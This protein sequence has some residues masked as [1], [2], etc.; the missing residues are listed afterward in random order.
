[1]VYDADSDRNAH[2]QGRNEST[3]TSPPKEAA[4]T[5]SSPGGTIDLHDKAGQRAP[6]EAGLFD[7]FRKFA[8]AEGQASKVMKNDGSLLRDDEKMGIS[9]I[10]NNDRPDIDRLNLRNVLLDSVPGLVKWNQKL[11]RVEADQET[12][13]KHNLYYASG[14]VEIGFD[15]VAVADGAWSK[16]RPLVTDVKA[17]YLGIT[18]IEL[19]LC[20]PNTLEKVATLCLTKVEPSST[21]ETTIVSYELMRLFANRK[22]GLK[23]AEPTGQT[24]MPSERP[25]FGITSATM[26]KM[27]ND[28]L[29]RVVM[30]SFPRRCEC[31]RLKRSG[32]LVLALLLFAMLPISRLLLL[33]LVSML[34][35][36]MLLVGL[37]PRIL[38]IMKAFTYFE[39]GGNSKSTRWS[40]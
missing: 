14:S 15:L 29:S 1:M 28:S 34:P 31:C 30:S 36:P 40:E 35:W 5:R 10:E 22:I 37:H 6:H 38:R 32:N 18:T 33:V 39:T 20:C 16:L 4:L 27:R 21:S 17:F 26:G 25:S 8:R 3:P 19:R 13:E 24:T 7:E 12:T 2:N 9:R 11:L 23:R